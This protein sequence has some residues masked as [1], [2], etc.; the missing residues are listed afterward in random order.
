VTASKKDNA[1][2]KKQEVY[3]MAF[4]GSE[5]IPPLEGD[6]AMVTISLKSSIIISS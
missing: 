1:G 3:S 2:Q 6:A 5:A 4:Y